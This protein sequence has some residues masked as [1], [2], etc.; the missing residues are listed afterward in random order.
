MV[1]PIGILVRF[2][3]LVSESA[4]AEE[5]L[6]LLGEAA[7]AHLGVD[8]AAVLRLGDDGELL[9]CAAQKL[10]EGVLGQRLPADLV[11]DD[12]AER[13]LW[14]CQGFQAAVALPLVSSGDLYGALVLL[15]RG[16]LSLTT[17]QTE[18]AGGLVDLTAVA[19]ARAS[20]YQALSR[21]YAELRASR[22]V[23]SRGEKLR[24]LG[25]MA[26]GVS[27]DLRNILSPLVLQAQQLR[28][29]GP[30]DAADR[31]DTLVRMEQVLWRGV[32]LVERLRSFSRQERDPPAQRLELN[33]LCEEALRLAQPRLRTQQV[34]L[35]LTLGDASAVHVQGAEFLSALLNLLVNALDVMPAGGVLRVTTGARDGGAYVSVADTGPG[36]APEAAGRLFEPFF[37]TKGEKGTGLG[38]SLVYAFAQRHG[39]SITGENLAEITG[40]PG[41]R[42]TLWLPAAP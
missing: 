30:E 20:Q 16:R 38:L 28:R 9:V 15:A 25:Q 17:A 37:T 36:I 8:G 26:S 21:S 42:F 34:H 35:S 13:L 22:E 12:L 40:A 19:L 29:M 32:E 1:S 4:A 7:L 11:G 31:E 6:P 24:A 3:R 2:S 18:L 10:P 23:L 27:H 39:G 33:A 14:L 5:I 41:A